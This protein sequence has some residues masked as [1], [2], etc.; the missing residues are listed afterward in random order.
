[1]SNAYNKISDYSTIIIIL[2]LIIEI[3]KKFVIN[4]LN[5]KK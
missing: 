3:L 2:I 1:M 4:N 5:L